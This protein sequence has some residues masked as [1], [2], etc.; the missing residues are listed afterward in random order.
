MRVRS[1]ALVVV[2]IG[3]VAAG[4]AVGGTIAYEWHPALPAVERPSPERLDPKLV[5]RGMELAAIGNCGTC[6]TKP[7]S[8]SLAGGLAIP[9]PFGRIYSTNIT[10]DPE[11]GIGRWSEAAFR[12]AMHQGVDREG[13]HLYPAFPYDHFT[14]VTGDDNRA[15][16]AYLMSRE[17]VR[18]ENPKGDL[19]FPFNLRIVLAGWK[20]LFL[21]RGPFRSDPGHDRVWNHGAYLVEGLAHCGAC[22]TPRN[23][24]GAER[25]DQRFAGG[26]AEGWTAY[27]LNADSPSPIPWDAEALFTYLR[28]GWHADHGVAR[29]PM[30]PVV[31]NLRT[32][33]EDDVRAIATYMADVLG[34]PST[35]RQRQAEAIRARLRAPSNTAVPVASASRSTTGQAASASQQGASDAS[36]GHLIY[37]STCAPCHESGRPLPYGGIDFEL[38]T[39]MQGPDAKNLV[40]VTL[41]GLPPAAGEA[42]PMMPG[43]GAVLSDQQLVALATYLRSRF[44]NRPPWSDVEHDVRDARAGARPVSIRPGSGTEPAPSDATQRERSQ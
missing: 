17:P 32:A 44:S 16:Y 21:P 38:S 11:T 4:A 20:L 31:E 33:P 28:Q 26:E 14:L 39:A 12:R 9:T 29:G 7:G 13:H 10:P 27:A 42:S 6:H 2:A 37:V 36:I 25:R 43:F 41:Y 5:Q 1:V 30:A 18:S 15:L 19:S 35:E 23:M 24:F 40:S 8:K 34:P 3:V 22:H